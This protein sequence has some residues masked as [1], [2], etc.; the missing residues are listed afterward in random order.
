MTMQILSPVSQPRVTDRQIAARPDTLDGLRIGLVDNQK[1]NACTLLDGVQAGLASRFPG[2]EF[3]R[4]LKIA[5]S[6]SPEAVMG[7]LEECDAVILAIA[8]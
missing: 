5:T 2:A 7:R 3:V 1:A 4:E 6:P 8:D